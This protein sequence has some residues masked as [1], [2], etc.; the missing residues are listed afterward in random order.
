MKHA[1][2]LGIAATAIAASGDGDSP[3]AQVRATI[4]AMETAAEARDVGD[5]TEHISAQFRDGY[6]RDSQE[7][8]RYVRGYF[9]AN[10]SVHLLTRI[11]SIEFPTQEEARARV[12]VAMAGRE[13]ESTNAWDLAGEIHDFDV[14]FMH[15]DG[16]W[17]VTYA[18]WK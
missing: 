15:E 14:T 5:L 17:K 6:G 2:A 7:L 18:K 12:T 10:Q 13:A 9:V 4:A 1:I 11:E 3:E 16:E 8:S